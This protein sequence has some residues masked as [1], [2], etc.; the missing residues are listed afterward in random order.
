MKRL[1]AVKSHAGRII[2]HAGTRKHMDSYLW[3]LGIL[4]AKGE[5][6]LPYAVRHFSYKC[7][8]NDTYGFLFRKYYSK[9]NKHAGV[10]IHFVRHFAFFVGRFRTIQ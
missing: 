5:N 6:F 2:N 9:L 1:R 4:L 3:K 8:Q 10:P 7:Q